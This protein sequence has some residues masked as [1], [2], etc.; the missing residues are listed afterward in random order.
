MAVTVADLKNDDDG[1]DVEL[2]IINDQD[3]IFIVD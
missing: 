2:L 3:S 1:L